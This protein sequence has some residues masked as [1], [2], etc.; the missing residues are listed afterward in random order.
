MGTQKAPSFP[1]YYRDWLHA[2]RRW[3]AETKIEYLEMLCEQADQPNGSIPEKLF[4]TE[5]LSDIVRDKFEKDANGFFNVRLRDILLKRDRFKA[6]RLDNLKGS[7]DKPQVEPHME[8]HVE[9]EEENEKGSKTPAKVKGTAPL[10]YPFADEVFLNRW[11]AWKTYKKEQ[12][13]FSYKHSGEQAALKNLGE[14][15]RGNLEVALAII[16]Q[17][18]GNGWK[19]FFELKGSGNDPKTP[20]EAADYAA[21]VKSAMK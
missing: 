16:Q 18:M 15:A 1:F 10:V 3:D 7:S 20:A 12:F 6:S 13:K 17:S 4:N 2:V 5:C 11:E 8:T 9:K 19:G 21:R 14:L